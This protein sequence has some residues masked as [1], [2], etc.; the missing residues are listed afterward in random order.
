MAESHSG[1]FYGMD[2]LQAFCVFACLLASF[3]GVTCRKMVMFA[4]ACDFSSCLVFR[5]TRLNLFQE[6]RSKSDNVKV[7]IPSAKMGKNFTKEEIAA[8]VHACNSTYPTSI[9]MSITNIYFIIYTDRSRVVWFEVDIY[10]RDCNPIIKQ[11]IIILFFGPAVMPKRYF[12]YSLLFTN[13]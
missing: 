12:K 4:A 11:L 1:K 9:G 7:D 2:R 13:V 8:M 3:A 5:V 10:D 6:Q